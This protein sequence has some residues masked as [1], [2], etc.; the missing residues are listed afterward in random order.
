MAGSE[1][2]QL[3]PVRYVWDELRPVEV[4]GVALPNASRKRFGAV[5]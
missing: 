4:R 5:P 2:P 3:V 1:S